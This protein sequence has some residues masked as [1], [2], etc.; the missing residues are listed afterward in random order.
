MG[1][2][3]ETIL[4]N[5]IR[6]VVSTDCP[7]CTLF[8]NHCG[9]LKD[10]R[11]GRLIT[12]GLAPGSPDLVGWK[13]VIVTPEMVGSSLA[14]FCGIEIKTPTGVVRADQLHWLSRLDVAGGISG[15]VRSTDDVVQLLNQ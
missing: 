8:R 11:T 13:T 9:A 2:Q 10:H 3:P 5:Q 1:A 12:F 14:V 4:Q 7:G 15:V 6:L